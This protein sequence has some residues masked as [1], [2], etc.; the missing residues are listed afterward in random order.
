MALT[1]LAD[2]ERERGCVREAARHYQTAASLPST[3]WPTVT[4]SDW[5]EAWV[6]EPRTECVGLATYMCALLLHQA[7]AFDEALP[8]LQRFGIRWRLAPCVWSAIVT[9]PSP[10]GA[11]LLPRYVGTL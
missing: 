11:P 7:L 3:E 4:P 8:Y 6:A 1:N 9:P 5:F 2:V 10:K